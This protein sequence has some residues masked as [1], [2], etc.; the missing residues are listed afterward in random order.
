[1]QK[2]I[3][4]TMFIVIIIIVIT[5]VILLKKKGVESFKFGKIDKK[6]FVILPFALLYLCLIFFNTFLLSKKD[7]INP[8]IV[9]VFAWFGVVLCCKGVLIVFLSVIAF[10]SSFRVGIDTNKPDKLIKTGIFAFSRNPIYI[11]FWFILL[12][13]LLVFQDIVFLLY[14]IASIWLF[15]RQILREEDFL[16]NYYGQ[17]YIEY[18][19]RVRR[20]V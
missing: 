4:A 1:M 8:I 9:E 15:H 3:V 12:G 7:I 6:D 11:G 20:Y 2:Y 17:E 16:K 14:L 10:K 5:R 18:C 19:K 13:Q